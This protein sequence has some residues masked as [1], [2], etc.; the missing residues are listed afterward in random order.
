MRNG[1]KE[2]GAAPACDDA[3]EQLAREGAKRM[4][5]AA[6][7]AE[8]EE[9]L[10]RARYERGCAFRGYRNGYAPGRTVAV[11]L[12]KV[13]VQP[14][15]VR[16]TPPAVGPFQSRIL[17]AY[18]RT[19]RTTKRLLTQ[20]YLEGLS[21]G[22]FEPV[23]RA[24]LG[25]TAPLSASSIGRLKAQWQAEYVAW[26]GRPLAAQYA[27][28]WVDGVYL[29]A[30]PQRDKT[31]V[32]VAIG[33][34]VDG[35]KE[36]LAMHEGYR[37]S[38]ASWAELLRDLR[39]RGVTTIR[40]VM[41]DGHLGIWAALGAVFP[42]AQGQRCWNH[43]VLNLLDTLP[44][45]LWADAKKA[46]RTIWQ[47]PTEAACRAQAATYAKRLRLLGQARAAE[48]LLRDL[49]EFV[50]FYQ[51]PQAHWKHLRTT[52]PIESV[53]AGVRLRTNVAKRMRTQ[54]TA[55]YLVFK[56]IERL[57][58]RWR[59]LNAPDLVPL[60]VEGHVFKD[61]TRHDE[62]GQRAA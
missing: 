6:M 44:K 34:T 23:F 48:T 45:R 25:E 20:L 16:A 26:K 31:A 22:D 3:L 13:A 32:L 62:E 19:S 21:S 14:P 58:G 8:V 59:V 42:T 40:L 27:Y 50:T 10:G 33:V 51:F 29:K 60:V 41:G 30:G 11:G 57:S 18:Q 61:G 9:F 7:E 35:T 5:R 56:L 2:T 17:A 4:L 46:L 54:E 28:V 53:F 47:A 38:T 55:L 49:D 39:T 36:L 24:L 43:K 37:E 52:N 15:R 1:S 12:G